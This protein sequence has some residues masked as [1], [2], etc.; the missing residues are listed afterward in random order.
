MTFQ[1]GDLLQAKHST[2]SLPWEGVYLVT[3]PAAN[4][5]AQRED[6]WIEVVRVDTGETSDIPASLFNLIGRAKK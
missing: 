2:I 5:G 3:G 6:E 1:K 4:A